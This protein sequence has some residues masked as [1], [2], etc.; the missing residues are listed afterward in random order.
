[1][2]EAQTFFHGPS[3]G[4]LGPDP[5]TGRPAIS[6]TSGFK[7]Q[8]SISF[9]TSKFFGWIRDLWDI[10]E[11]DLLECVGLD[12]AMLLRF[13]KMSMSLFAACMVPGLLV[14]LP[15]NYY[16]TDDKPS[17]P[18]NWDGSNDVEHQVLT[19]SGISLLHIF[20]QFIFTWVFSLLT[21]RMIWLTY[22]GYIIARRGYLIKR[23]KV[24]VNRTIM[25]VGL[26]SELQRDKALATFYEDLGVGTVESAYVCRHVTSLKQRIE[27]RAHA[28][29]ALEEAYTEYYGNPS[30]RQ[31]YD[32]EVVAAENDSVHQH[33][34]TSSSGEGSQ[35]PGLLTQE[36]PPLA[37]T[38]SKI[39]KRPTIRLGFLG[40]FGKK[41]KINYRREV[42]AKLDEEVQVMR[43]KIAFVPTS[44][45]FV[46]FEEMHT[47][48]ILAQTV[49]TQQTLIYGT[50]MAPEP[51][52]VYWDNLYLPSTE[53]NLR[54]VVVNVILFVLIFFWAGP[55]GLLSSFLNLESLNKLFPRISKFAGI[56]P[57]I[58]SLIQGF[59]PTVG[60]IIFLAV[61]PKILLSLCQL[62]G[63]RSHSEIA[64][65]LYSKYFTFILFNVVLVFTVV[66]TWAQAFN[67][68]YH[69][70][71]ELSLL[72]AASLPRVA[73]FF[74][75]Y[76]IL[77]GI[78]LF[79]LQL[80]QIGDVFDQ[81]FKNFIS[82]TPRDYAEARAPPELSY[83]V[84]YANASLVFVIVLIYSCIRPL[85]LVFGVIYF[86]VGY[87]VLKYQL[88]Y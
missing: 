36:Q 34:A 61:V 26:P 38:K 15:I 78:G 55:V 44:T 73:P 69:N 48:Q 22:E 25:V 82:K 2:N 19:A 57:V 74:V 80:L 10:S 64:R 50:T 31:D 1:M 16:L 47:V 46:T 40:L 9:K 33:N 43:T 21:L 41:D 70:P 18:T 32:P 83:G 3:S 5:A 24:I 79:P 17:T 72:L 86:A 39:K 62:Q 37:R 81:I 51:R 65:I 28:L 12:A 11:D 27:Q 29:R 7:T 35:G 53:L 54:A 85:I 4:N 88:L 30:N 84:V 52:D 8:V 76:T 67:K 45:G 77:R 68:V 75:N 14:V 58:K 13:F 66:G 42:F 49:N 56:H 71:G 6:N 59:L 63:F 60:V 20:T 23:Q 87:L